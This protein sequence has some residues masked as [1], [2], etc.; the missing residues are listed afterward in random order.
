M[1]ILLKTPDKRG[2]SRYTR[3]VSLVSIDMIQDINACLDALRGAQ[4]TCGHCNKCLLMLAA[5]KV[6]YTIINF[7][8][9]FYICRIVIARPHARLR[10][11]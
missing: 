8:K 2:K 5:K 1:D 4:L 6:D 7:A 10:L 11:R 9:T 3:I